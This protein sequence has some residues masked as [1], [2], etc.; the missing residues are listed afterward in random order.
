MFIPSF[1]P[2]SPNRILPA[3]QVS[4]PAAL[5]A[6]FTLALP[7]TQAGEPVRPGDSWTL[8]ICK[9]NQAGWS[10][11]KPNWTWD[12]QNPLNSTRDGFWSLEIQP[13]PEPTLTSEFKL[14][15]PGELYEF[16]HAWTDGSG[17][18][19]PPHFYKDYC[20]ATRSSG[21]AEGIFPENGPSSAI[22]FKIPQDGTYRVRVGGE[23]NVQI[24]AVGFAS[25][26]LYTLKPDRSEKQLLKRQLCNAKE[27]LG[28]YPST[29]FFEEEMPLRAGDFLVLRIQTI[30]PGEGAAGRSSITFTEFDVTLRSLLLTKK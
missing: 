15:V 1:F 7:L 3:L 4:F 23:V 13:A 17:E 10:K 8:P 5:L 22:L 24:P 19:D 16:E 12:V 18:F 25:V 9:G 20:L 26:C 28:S 30:S 11:Q 14:M 27:G 6:V 21:Q 29:W 2:L